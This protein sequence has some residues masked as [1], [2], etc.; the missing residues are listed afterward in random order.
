MIWSWKWKKMLLSIS[1]KYSYFK[2]TFN[3]IR[4]GLWK[5]TQ[6]H[7][8]C[9][10]LMCFHP[11]VSLSFKVLPNLTLWRT[12]KVAIIV[13][14]FHN[15]SRNHCSWCGQGRSIK[16]F[17]WCHCKNWCCIIC[18]CCHNHRSH[19]CKGREGTFW[20]AMDNFIIE[21]I[22]LHLALWR[23]IFLFRFFLTSFSQFDAKDEVMT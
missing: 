15:R 1:F 9:D 6:I 14:M 19:M 12:S 13:N 2:L 21:L 3:Y 4:K 8:N 5:R 11:Y 20:G 17:H 10:T 7:Q 18:T 16:F 22:I 23:I